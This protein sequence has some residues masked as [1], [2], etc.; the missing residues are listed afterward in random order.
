MRPLRL[1]M[2]A[3]GPYATRQELD[4]AEL[5]GAEFFLIHGPTG[6]GKTT[7]LDAMAYALY[8]ET[9]GAG[10][11]G[12]QMRSQQA[13][14]A[15]ETR[16]RFDF[17]IGADHYRVE[18]SPEQEVAKRRGSGT[19]WRN[20]EAT[21]WRGRIPGADPGQEDDGWIPMATRSQTVGTEVI[22][23]LG[24]SAEQFRQVILIPQG[25][26][27]EVLEADSRRREEILES[28]FGTQRFSL[29]SDRLKA[30][31]Q[32]LEEKARRG[33][34]E[35]TALLQALGVET[36]EA[37]ESRLA[38]LSGEVAQSRTDLGLHKV[39]KDQ[40]A[41]RLEAG[42]RTEILFREAEVA[43]AQL[44]SFEPRRLAVAA[45]RE[46]IVLAR[47]ASTL[48]AAREL[49]DEAHR[50]LQAMEAELSAVQAS[51]PRLR[52]SLDSAL[53]RRSAVDRLEPRRQEWIAEQ[54][55]LEALRPRLKE[56]QQARAV[57]E[58]TLR[59][60]AA[61]TAESNA[62]R[63]QAEAAAARIPGAE[64]RWAE[65]TTAQARIP[66]LE[67]QRESLSEQAQLALRRSTLEK[68]RLDLIRS[69]EALRVQG[70]SLRKHHEAAVAVREAEQARWDG[71]QSALLASHL[72][73]GHPCPVCGSTHHPT[74]ALGEPGSVPSET[75]LRSTREAEK[76]AAESLEEARE[77]FRESERLLDSL[78][79]ELKTLPPVSFA[80][81]E[82]IPQ[83][84]KDLGSE[85]AA[86]KVLVGADPARLLAQVR[87]QAATAR[88]RAEQADLRRSDVEMRSAR[89]RTDL[90]VLSRQIPEELH[91][92][93][94]LD[95]RLQKV[96]VELQRLAEA[97]TTCEADLLS[98]TEQWN[99]AKAREEEMIRT[100]EVSREDSARRSQDWASALSSAGFAD[101]PA[102]EEACLRPEVLSAL[103]MEVEAFLAARTAAQDR[104]LRARTAL[105]L[106]A[107][108]ERPDL[109][110][111]AQQSAAA[112][113]T[114][115]A[116]LTANARL[117]AEL[118]RL[119]AGSR[120]IAEMELAFGE[121]ERTYA[122][123]G[124]IAEAVSGRN[125]SGLTLQR[126]VLTAFLDDTLLAASARL[127][128]MSRGRYRLERRLERSD[129]RR[130]SGLDL[131]V[132]DE[133]TGFARSVNTLSGGE[134]FLASLALALGLADVVQ[135]HSGGLRMEALFIDEGFGTLDPEALDEALKVLM[136]LR[137]NGRMVGIISHVPE[138][139]ER[140]DV[141]LEV[142]SSRSGSTARFVRLAPSSTAP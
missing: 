64:A 124:R 120:R 94:V 91:G 35:R 33:Q 112:D 130:A 65:A 49:R 46:R 136:D 50:R 115:Q 58:E 90:E 41:R 121:L 85:L 134:S 8:G 75:R 51:L 113:E 18:R 138:L 131:D 66:A 74:P 39:G 13:D 125:P 1:L 119:E 137:E 70:S 10:R 59:Q 142:S 141:R 135:S 5:G 2:E 133:H 68:K 93:D 47:K 37:L 57:L 83:A 3:F 72:Q 34:Q 99:G 104:D 140:I 106:A 77:R 88:L 36:T 9:S 92:A 42:R 126:F 69:L 128:R 55:R 116:A 61:A 4:F 45:T 19:T 44:E 71:G 29:L 87:E 84:L 76:A 15:L 27:R 23:M 86:L 20:P 63:L 40:A 111:L 105:E 52:S 6:S 81:P 32:A 132:F 89:H 98:C 30:R 62:F 80:N 82:A 22:R 79:T 43:R 110:G 78:Q 67:A 11:S 25:R 96:L 54:T 108:A 103:E 7:L 95:A 97:R 73:E 21:L 14:P 31:A 28:L 117:E 53:E 60:A 129:L 127:V 102:W 56:H 100:R 107:P 123:A 114:H 101:A 17:R 16:V 26:F 48:G 38:A 12:A 24:F 122:V 118:A 109:P 139:R